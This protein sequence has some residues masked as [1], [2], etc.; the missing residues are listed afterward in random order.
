MQINLAFTLTYFDDCSK[1]DSNSGIIVCISYIK[2]LVVDM[3]MSASAVA[4]IIKFSM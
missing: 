4:Q 3:V 2:P 1:F